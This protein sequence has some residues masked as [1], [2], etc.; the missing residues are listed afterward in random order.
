MIFQNEGSINS[1]SQFHQI[2]IEA[3]EGKLKRSIKVENHHNLMLKN[4]TSCTT[5]L[6]SK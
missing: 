3:L 2:M 6:S 5:L 1:T 4:D